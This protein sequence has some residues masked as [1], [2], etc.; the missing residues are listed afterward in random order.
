MD[1]LEDAAAEAAEKVLWQLQ[2]KEVVEIGRS[3]RHSTMI[4]VCEQL[5]SEDTVCKVLVL[6]GGISVNHLPAF[7][8][9][10]EVNQSIEGLH[11]VCL[12]SFEELE[13][14]I[15]CCRRQPRI[16]TLTL[17]NYS[18]T[19]NRR[20]TQDGDP[21]QVICETI[22]GR[23]EAMTS[24]TFSLNQKHAPRIPNLTTLEIEGYPIGTK[25]IEMLANVLSGNN[26][27]LTLRLKDCSLR[28]DVACFLAK[29]IKHNTCLREL[30]LSYNRHFLAPGMTREMT[31]KTLVQRGLRFNTS[32]V[33][34][35]MECAF[36]EPVK[37]KKIQQQVDINRFRKKCIESGDDM[38]SIPHP[39][40]GRLL[41]R[42]APKP[43]T[44]YQF[45]RDGTAL[46]FP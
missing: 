28:S 36:G 7:Q 12:K 23:S 25:G 45:L 37:A 6:R 9:A 15:E 30:D 14:A 19:G 32:L 2:T 29:M 44:L 38:F 41:T 31:F 13:G 8:E 40:W 5:E 39:L 10:L 21:A 4:Q 18:A 35:K 20:R 22:F 33:D 43:S 16:Q 24:R 27:L 17:E 34:F 46:L 1:G 26:T 3:S 11:F 42:V